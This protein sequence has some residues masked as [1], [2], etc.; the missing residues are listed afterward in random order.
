MLAAANIHSHQ[1]KYCKET[2]ELLV[3]SDRFSNVMTDKEIIKAQQEEIAFLKQEIEELKKRLGL[4]SS[5]SSKPP[6][7]EGLGKKPRTMSL[8][9]SKNSRG[10][11][12]G[13][14]G[15]TLE[16]VENPD[17]IEVHKV[18]VCWACQAD[19]SETEAE[20]LVKRQV[21]D[22]EIK[23]VVTEHQAEVKRCKC[24]ACSTANF[25]EGVVAP[26][27]IG[28]TFRSIALYLSGQFIAKD[29]LS[30]AMEDLFGVPISDTTL[31]KYEQQLSE[32][33]G[34]LYQ[35]I[36]ERIQA[37]KVKHQDESGLR[38]GGKTGWIHVFCTKLFTYL[39]YD[40]KRKSRIETGRG[41]SVHDHYKPYLQ[42]EDVDHS[43]CNAHHLRE[44]KALMLYEQEEWAS[45]MYTLLK[46]MNQS[47]EDETSLPL[48]KIEFLR[49]AYDKVVQRGFD[50]HESLAPPPSLKKS[51][52]GRKKRRTG[53]NL[54]LRFRNHKND[55]LRFLSDPNIPFTN[56]QAE[57]DL[58]MVKLKQKVSGCLRTEAG[59]RDF[60]V[61]R[62]FIGTIRKHKLNILDSIK[63]ALHQ[64]ISLFDILP[65]EYPQQ[66]LLSC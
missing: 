41:T 7:I 1:D 11:Q 37:S 2:R 61:I 28:D 36:L 24:G 50:Y 29:R 8:R 10:G 38:V 45:E 43:F 49:R 52:R 42:E 57:R 14:T 33:L 65:I 54:L 21:V 63:L 56:N 23:R 48:E 19:L 62:S 60:A 31:I 3:E 18:D 4:D 32:N 22:I 66:L 17:K 47:T 9:S 35:Q 64:R 12:P 30:M 51:P 59:A 58:R 39:W 16:S 40:R 55:V 13:H 5:N 20:R 6:S 34:L 25:P 26:T 44:L 46:I 15:K 27:Q 53:H